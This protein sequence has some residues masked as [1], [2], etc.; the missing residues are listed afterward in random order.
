M[1][2][3]RAMSVLHLQPWAKQ[4]EEE[5]YDNVGCQCKAK[6]KAPIQEKM[7]H[8]SCYIERIVHLTRTLELRLKNISYF[9]CI[10]QQRVHYTLCFTETLRLSFII[11][12]TALK[13]ASGK[14]ISQL[15]YVRWNY[16]TMSREQKVTIVTNI[17]EF[18]DLLIKF[19]RK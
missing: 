13:H 16:S 15:R 5:E 1:Y 6:T 12:L 2:K 9:I 14:R 8:Y 18:I 10:L 17:K 19:L 7:R 3:K 4:E 11:A